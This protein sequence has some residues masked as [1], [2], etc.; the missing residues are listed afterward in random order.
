MTVTIVGVGLIGG[1]LALDLKA[2]GF[3]QRVIG[4]DS[5]PVHAGEAVKLGLVDEIKDLPEALTPADLV[6]LAMSVDEVVRVL[7]GVLDMV[8]DR[9][10]VTDAISISSPSSRK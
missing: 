9:A 4:V 6:V 1:S 7:P 10:L 3:A 5:N 2:R 8:G